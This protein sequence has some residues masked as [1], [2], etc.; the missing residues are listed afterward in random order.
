[1]SKINTSLFTAAFSFAAELYG[2]V[3]DTSIA[4]AD[5]KSNLPSFNSASLI[6]C[7]NYC[8]IGA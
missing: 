5:N 2:S 4:P 6:N 8:Y 7:T 3:T 1:M